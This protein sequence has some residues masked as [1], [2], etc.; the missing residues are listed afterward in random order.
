MALLKLPRNRIG[1][2]GVSMTAPLFVYGTLR[3]PDILSGVLARPLNGGA[4]LAATAPGFRPVHY[5]GRIYPALQ[6]APGEAAPGLLL[7]DLTA[8]EMDLIDAFEGDEYRREIIPTIIDEE[9]H[10]AWAYL[11][12]ISIP[13]GAEIWTLEAWQAAHKPKVLA[14]ERD[15]AAQLRQKLIAIRP[16]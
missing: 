7:T 5:P 15:N 10:E 3:D 13:D 11:P 6:R 2:A 1:M 14:A 12:A 9:L 8:F 16:N 4:M